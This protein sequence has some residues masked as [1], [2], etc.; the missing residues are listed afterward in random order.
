MTARVKWLAPTLGTLVLLAACSEPGDSS[1]T[2]DAPPAPTTTTAATQ[3]EAVAEEQAEAGEALEG[4][5]SYLADAPLFRDCKT[6]RVVPVAMAG[7]YMEIERAYLDS[8]IESDSE[9]KV[10]VHGRYLERPK[11][12]G[13]S[14]E[15]MLVI[16]SFDGIPDSN[17]CASQASTASPPAA[18]SPGHAELENTFW[19]LVELNG[20]PV[21]ERP[22]E[23]QAHLVFSAG[24]TRVNGFAGCNR[25]FGQYVRDGAKLSFSALGSTRMACPE[26]MDT[27]QA[28]LG[29]LG[30]TNRMELDGVFL[31]LYSNDR[32]V[33]RLEAV[34]LPG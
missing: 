23:Q 26:G 19:K 10:A 3:A 4:M 21:P 30:E 9:L 34:Y 31:E 5:F 17:E 2:G 13:N 24:E 29:A 12:E 15:I 7:P 11:M 6:G 18:G 20:E 28:F 8:G 32:L 16:D 22:G 27:E 33:A 14:N 25:F 1:T